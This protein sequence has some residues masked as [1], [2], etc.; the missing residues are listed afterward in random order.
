MILKMYAV[1]VYY[2]DNPSPDIYYCD[3]R[4]ECEKLAQDEWEYD[5][6][7]YGA[8]FHT[9]EIED[10]VISDE[11]EDIEAIYIPSS[12]YDKV[13]HKDGTKDYIPKDHLDIHYWE[14][15]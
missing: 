13:T 5:A 1:R 4:E 14:N 12:I 3:T 2:K 15:G 9:T 10:I 11:P 7:A 6:C 8:D